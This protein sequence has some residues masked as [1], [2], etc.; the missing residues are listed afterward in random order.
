MGVRT[1]PEELTCK[2]SLHRTLN[3]LVDA[4]VKILLALAIEMGL[5]SPLREKS[6]QFSD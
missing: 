4:K 5:V 1:K 3:A 6:S 2:I